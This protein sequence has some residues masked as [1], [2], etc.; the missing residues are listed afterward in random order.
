MIHFFSLHFSLSILY[1]STFFLSVEISFS[2]LK[3][4]SSF[5]CESFF[6]FSN[7]FSLS[8][9]FLLSS[10]SSSCYSWPLGKVQKRK[11]ERKREKEKKEKKREKKEKE[12]EK[13]R[14]RKKKKK[15]KELGIPAW[16]CFDCVSISDF[17]ELMWSS[18]DL[19]LFF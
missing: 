14:K 2:S 9:C 18:R 10:S 5:S 17:R 4:F 16:C 8:W 3:I 15:D 11:K 12:K 7:S 13:K 6:E 1:S 19:T